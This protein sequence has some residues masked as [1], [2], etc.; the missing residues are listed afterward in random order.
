[1]CTVRDDD[2]D[3]LKS[4]NPHA[5]NMLG[6]SYG[7]CLIHIVDIVRQYLIGI[8]SSEDVLYTIEDGAKGQK[9]G[10]NFLNRIRDDT[11]LR[12]YWHLRNVRFIP[13]DLQMMD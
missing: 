12:S 4:L 2:F 7:I 1:V 10:E 8:G 13:K 5:A 11:D 3:S 6:T 9:Q